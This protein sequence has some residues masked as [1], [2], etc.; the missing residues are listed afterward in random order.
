[1]LQCSS[2]K[3]L[4]NN[5]ILLK[6]NKILIDGESA[7][8]DAI[9]ELFIDSPNKTFIGVPFEIFFN[10]WAKKDPDSSFNVW[11]SKK[12]KRQQRWEKIFFQ[13]THSGSK[14]QEIG[15]SMVKGDRSTSGIIR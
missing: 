4:D 3:Y 8:N 5:A 11:L 13:T 15:Q 1:M 6:K 7:T 2:I 12:K 14:L 10:Q 9:N